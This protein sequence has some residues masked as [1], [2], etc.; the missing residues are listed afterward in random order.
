MSG[1]ANVHAYFRSQIEDYGTMHLLRVWLG[2]AFLKADG[3]RGLGKSLQYDLRHDAQTIVFG[4]VP[5]AWYL[6]LGREALEA[7]ARSSIL[8]DLRE[9]I[10]Y[11]YEIFVHMER[12]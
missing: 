5:A 6:S 9:L 3:S 7:M 11:R 1:Y 10:D 4:P 8:K 2:D 12:L